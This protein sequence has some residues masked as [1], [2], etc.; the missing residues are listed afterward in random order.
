MTSFDKT[1]I[2]LTTALELSV[3]IHDRYGFTSKSTSDRATDTGK[4]SNLDA[5]G[6]PIPN[7]ARL[8]RQLFPSVKV[9]ESEREKFEITPEH[10]SQARE[11]RETLQAFSFKAIER[12][13][14]NFE[15]QVLSVV[16]SD[17]ITHKDLGRVASFPN[18]YER[19]ISQDAW[20]E[21]E[22]ELARNSE[23]VGE[24][25]SR[26]EFDVVIENVRYLSRTESYLICA[27]ESGKNIIKFFVHER[28]LEGLTEGDTIKLQ[29]YVKKQEVSKYHGGQETMLNRVK[30]V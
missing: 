12:S 23:F 8:Y 28:K 24:E 2:P 19:K 5:Q 13:L 14:T 18:V 6:N 29:G 1:N 16:N 17:T 3:A 25:L 20:E 15:Q 11:I 4:E 7:S 30:F 9:A 21:R 27:S 22:A 26:A 10:V